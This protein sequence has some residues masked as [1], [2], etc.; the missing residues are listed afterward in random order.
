[1]LHYNALYCITLHYITLHYIT[2]HYITLHCVTLHCVTLH[3]DTLCY[4]TYITT[5][6]QHHLHSCWCSSSHSSQGHKGKHQQVNESFVKFLVLAI[7]SV[8]N[9]ANI[10]KSQSMEGSTNNVGDTCKPVELV[11][12]Y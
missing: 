1:M 10:L 11:A 4:I 12:I 7:C 6:L 2:L 9:K 8:S 5:S 3:Y